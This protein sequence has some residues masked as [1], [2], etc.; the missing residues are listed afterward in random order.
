MAPDSGPPADP[1]ALSSHEPPAAP[2]GPVSAG[3]PE[4][5]L[6]LLQ[7][8]MR[9][10]CGPGKGEVIW[11]A[12]HQQGLINMLRNPAQIATARRT[13]PTTNS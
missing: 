4:I 6:H 5:R 9:E 13:G 2:T 1:I 3:K 7:I 10:R 12:P 8:G 11:R